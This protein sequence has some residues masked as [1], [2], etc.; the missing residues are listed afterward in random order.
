LSETKSPPAFHVMS[1]HI[2]SECNMNCDYCFFLQKER[3]YRGSSFRMTD[4]VLELYIS[5]YIEAQ[6][7][8]EVI[9]TWQGGEP[10]MMGLNFFRRSVEYARKY[11]PSGMRVEYSIQTNGTLLDEEWCE[12]LRDNEF[13]VGLSLDGPSEL[14]DRYRHDKRGGG[15]FDRVMRAVQLMQKNQVEFN[16]LCTVNAANAGRPLEV[17]RFFRDELRVKWIQFIPIVERINSDGSTLLQEG[18]NVTDRSV[19]P[20]QWGA[21]LVEIFDDWLVRD[22][23]EMH[24]NMFEAGFASWVGAPAL[25]CIFEET[26]GNALVIEHNGDLYS[27]D[28]FVEPGYLLGNI[29]ETPLVTLLSSEKQRRFGADKRDTLP[30]FCRECKVLFACRGECPKNRFVTA[31]G[32]EHGLNYLCPGYKAFF[33]HVDAPMRA[34]ADLYRA[35]RSP[36]EI[37]DAFIEAGRNDPCPCGSGRKYKQCHMR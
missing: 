23:G 20:E 24:V 18:S 3:L 19:N 7:V 34:M 11:T 14:H 10:T 5:Q 13:L 31:P 27:C 35:G 22:V 12:F 16:I 36:S 30:A 17:Y 4:E 29:L 32:G 21:F 15:T 26:C 1:K 33:E 28:H 37:L 9:I 25:A 2:G 8:P 6:Q